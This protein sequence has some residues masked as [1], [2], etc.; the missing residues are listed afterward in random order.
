MLSVVLP[1]TTATP[2]AKAPAAIQ[3]DWRALDLPGAQSLD[4][5]LPS[6]W[7]VTQVLVCPLRCGADC[8]PI[9]PHRR[10]D[11]TAAATRSVR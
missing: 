6:V 1:A 2:Y 11:Q 5:T 7:V 4:D 9:R 3:L 8:P 10:D